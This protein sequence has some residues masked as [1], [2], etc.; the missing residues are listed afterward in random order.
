MVCQRA[1]KWKPWIMSDESCFQFFFFFH[2]DDIV[3]SESKLVN[4]TF[5]HTNEWA[6]VVGN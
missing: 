5:L 1:D 2:K 6:L 4:N 3:Q